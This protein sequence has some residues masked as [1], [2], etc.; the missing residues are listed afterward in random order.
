MVALTDPTTLR[1]KWLLDIPDMDDE[2]W[3]DIWD[4][5]FKQLLH[6][7]YLTPLRVHWL[8]PII[9]MACW[10]CDRVKGDFFH[11]FWTCPV[12]QPFWKSVVDIISKV[13]QIPF[14]PSPK[15]CLLDLVKGLLSTNA[16]RTLVGLLL[17]YARKAFALH[18]KKPSAPTIV[19]S[20]QLVNS[21]LPLYKITYANRGGF[22]KFDKIWAKCLKDDTTA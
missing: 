11:I 22:P 16:G 18:W 2:D 1:H 3:A 19:Y 21:Q 17:F 14:T 8:N 7:A 10:H 6:R 12:I 15:I 13:A 20:E 4:A 9:P 5:P